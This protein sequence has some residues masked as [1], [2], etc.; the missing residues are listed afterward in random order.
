MALIANDILEDVSFVLVEA[1]ANTTLGTA[2]AG[3]GSAT[4]QPGSLAAI[5]VGARLI[6]GS[7]AAEEIITVTAIN[8]PYF[9]AT[10]AYAHAATD[11]LYGATFP[12]G[13]PDFFLWT[14]DEMLGYLAD[15]QKDFL[16]RTGCYVLVSDV[17]LAIATPVNTTLGTAVA[18]SASATVTPASIAG[19][20]AG[21]TLILGS[22][23]TQ[24]AIVVAS[25]VGAQFTAYFQFAHAA[26]G[27]VISSNRF[28]AQP[29]TTVRIE[30]IALA[31]LDL[32][33]TSQA[34][35][36]MFQWS[37]TLKQSWQADIGT[38][39]N[40]FQDE[41]GT[42]NFGVYPL[43]NAAGTLELW[44]TDRGA[45][46]LDLNTTLIVP[47]ICAFYLK[48]YVLMRCFEKAGEMRDPQRAKFCLEK[49]KMGCY[50]TRKLVM[51][52]SAAMKSAYQPAPRRSGQVGAD[53]EELVGM[54]PPG[55]PQQAR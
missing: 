38:P 2:V 6:C 16:L 36:D 45:D 28:Y 18:G 33:D 24:E 32:L 22:G 5:Y 10:F 49:Y 55:E 1:F 54:L 34:D 4:V 52:V 21:A 37:D 14:Q 12:S 40:W 51:G 11:A 50:L 26:T 46:S 48:Y 35:L 17:A 20:T 43:P 27:A 39:V 19:I 42:E 47:D 8:A 31:G 13:Q 30:R 15:A 7:G 53:E 3:A 9:T 25:V 29:E 41:S 23:A 44:C